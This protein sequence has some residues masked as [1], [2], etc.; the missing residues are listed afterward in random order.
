[1]C[2]LVQEYKDLPDSKDRPA[3]SAYKVARAGPGRPDRLGL[4]V[5][6][7]SRDGLDALGWMASPD[8]L[9]PPDTPGIPVVQDLWVRIDKRLVLLYTVLQS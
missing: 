4:W 9:A 1:M 3:S 8:F 6:L 2:R 5:S 7:E